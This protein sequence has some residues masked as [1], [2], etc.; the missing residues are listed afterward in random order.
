M[1]AIFLDVTCPRCGY[2]GPA[3]LVHVPETVALPEHWTVVCPE[4]SRAWVV[5]I[6]CSPA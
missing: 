4:C 3:A 1:N 6:V 2:D 5:E